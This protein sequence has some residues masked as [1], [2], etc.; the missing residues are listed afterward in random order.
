MRYKYSY[1]TYLSVAS[2]SALLMP[3]TWLKTYILD[4]SLYHLTLWRSPHCETSTLHGRSTELPAKAFISVVASEKRK[5]RAV[6]KNAQCA[7]Y[8]GCARGRWN[9]RKNNRQKA[10]EYVELEASIFC[11]VRAHLVW[12]SL[13][14]HGNF[15]I[16]TCL[17]AFYEHDTCWNEFW[18]RRV[19]H[20]VL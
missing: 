12:N 18:M 9:L 4:V 7:V 16:F 11:S 15:N 6:T 13:N 10:N 20:F 19:R 17:M 14:L 8:Y 2:P 5:G 1:D 3:P